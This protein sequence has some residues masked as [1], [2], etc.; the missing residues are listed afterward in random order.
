M[1]SE[2]PFVLPIN[3]YIRDLD[4]LKHYVDDS[5]SFLSIST[6]KTKEECKK[7]VIESLKPGG[8]F[9]F[10]DPQV[11]YLKRAD[12][13]D[14]APAET[15]LVKYIN[16]S[17]QTK[18]LMAPTLTTYLH[19]TKKLSLLSVSIEDGV[20]A[21]NA[22]KSAMFKAK[23]DGDVF[24]H[25][26]K[27]IEQTGKKLAGNA[28]TGALVSPSTA[29]VNKTGH[30]TLTSN[31]RATAGYGNANNEKFLAGNRHYFNHHIVLN[32]I[33]SI[34][35]NCDLNKISIVIEK[36]NLHIPSAQ[37]V[38]EAIKYSTDLYWWETHYFE[39]IADLV[40]KLSPLQ[41]AAFL[42]IGDL[43]H[44]KKYNDAFVRSMLDKLIEKVE[45]SHPDP[46]SVLKTA[47]DDH[48][49]L[50]HRIC[51]KEMQG[52]GKEYKHLVGTPGH[53]TV[54]LT[55]LNIQSTV[56]DYADLIDVFWRTSNMPASMAYFPSSIRRVVLT[57]DTDS[58]IFTLQDWVVWYK[59]KISFDEQAC[60]VKE[61]L[62]YLTSATITHLLAGMSANFG[63]VPER[64]FEIEMKNEYSFPVFVPTY[65][66]KHYFALR[67]AQEGN[68]FASDKIEIEIKGV[69][70]KSSNAPRQTIHAAQKM[71]RDIM[72]DVMN[73]GS[74]SI[75]KYIKQ[76]ADIERV[77]IASILKG[78][79]TYLRRGSIKDAA[80][81]TASEELSPFMQHKLYMDV[82][83]PKYGEIP[84]PP[85]DTL[86]ISTTVNTPSSFKAWVEN[87]PD[88]A[89]ANRMTK[90]L[91]E[92]G[93]THIGTF[94]FPS[95]VLS[96]RG[97]PEELKQIIAYRK[98][99]ADITKIFSVIMETLGSFTM[100][101]KVVR[102]YSDYY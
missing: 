67:D 50:M 68:I 9:E 99:V 35:G 16:E 85:Y 40:H 45:G 58:T 83:S 1:T 102:L 26:F 28:V 70:L 47:R 71:M 89:F 55:A 80:S 62:V 33:I 20:K 32:N 8:Q 53:S 97:M 48:L 95:Q 34:I 92:T 13:S 101:K 41:R 72:E 17:V 56:N 86:K 24:K 78:E 100:D 91:E 52:K 36:Y 81:Y 74:V 10:K 98:I 12:N 19:P 73:K 3:E 82:F 60:S 63:I 4:I 87:I 51:K 90:W 18:E 31:C 75:F 76:I 57:G 37:E 30:S 39:K 49:Y 66:G 64:L 94:N 59:G 79:H 29:L 14:R 43:Y 21:R 61:A 96:S 2:N 25:D 42:Y 65:L 46:Q 5:A 69:G 11:K 27:K 22:A 6:G 44:L 77:I 88:R 15:T 54:A 84:P 23:A 38:L 93:R 7:F